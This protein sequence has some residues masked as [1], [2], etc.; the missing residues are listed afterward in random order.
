MKR[1]G[2]ALSSALATFRVALRSLRL[3]LA[4]PVHGSN[5]LIRLLHSVVHQGPQSRHHDVIV[6]ADSEIV[7]RIIVIRRLRIQRM[8]AENLLHP[9]RQVLEAGE[10][11]DIQLIVCHRILDCLRQTAQLEL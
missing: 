3:Q 7:L 4:R 11:G 1:N 8:R 6:P 9:A 10:R 2:E 5:R